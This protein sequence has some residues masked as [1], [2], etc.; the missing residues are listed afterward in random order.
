MKQPQDIQVEQYSMHNIVDLTSVFEGIASMKIAQIKNQVMQS[1]NFFDRLWQMYSQISVGSTFSFGHHVSSTDIINK[2][3]YI[4]I[5]A[6]GGFSGDIDQKLISWML[7]SYDPA[8]NDI[9]VIGHHGAV[10]L[11]QSNVSFKKYF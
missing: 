8:K 5:T 9:I 10:Q 4:V 2:E 7:N 1:K 11:A 3:L 6:E